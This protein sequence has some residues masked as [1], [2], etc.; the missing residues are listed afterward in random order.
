MLHNP[1]QSRSELSPKQ[2]LDYLD[3]WDTALLPNLDKKQNVV[4][5]IGFTV[6]DESRFRHVIEEKVRIS[7]QPFVHLVFH[8]L[9]VL[10]RLENNDVRSFF[11]RINLDRMMSH[12]EQEA[13]IEKIIKLTDGK[14]ERIVE[15]LEVGLRN[16]FANLR[17]PSQ[18]TVQEDDD[19]WGY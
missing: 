9:S 4:L 2:L 10:H 8:F 5:G 13:V 6:S 1:I 14:Y 3:W 15:E 17:Q 12:A 7:S 18:V 16:Q 19:E 11:R